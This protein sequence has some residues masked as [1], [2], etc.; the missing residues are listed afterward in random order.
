[1]R[2]SAAGDTNHRPGFT[3]V[4]VSVAM[5]TPRVDAWPTI[6][7]VYVNEP[8][9]DGG[10]E[11]GSSETDGAFSL[12][13]Q[14]QS[15]DS[16]GERQVE[17]VFSPTDADHYLP[18]TRLESVSVA[19]RTVERVVTEV[20]AVTGAKTG[21]PLDALGLPS[22]VTI[23][24]SGGREYEVP[25]VWGGYDATATG[26][27]TLTGT[28]DLSAVAG[29]VEQAAPEVTASATVTLE[30]PAP[31]AQKP[32]PAAPKAAPTLPRTGDDTPAGAAGLALVA[33]AACLA[34]GIRVSRRT[35][36]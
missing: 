36:D 29:E 2:V 24:T 27:Q 15:W 23:A 9:G 30:A 16:P 7:S 6:G 32:R 8:L 10:L 22:A 28:L 4:T 31:A 26:P 35:R 34:L 11:G 14:G 3:E 21:T 12:A 17:V 19:R 1:M 25:V 18:L 13:V 5:G 33:G 20:P